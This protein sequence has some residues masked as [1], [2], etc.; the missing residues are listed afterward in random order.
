MVHVK[1][2]DVVLP[3]PPGH[4]EGQSEIF[5]AYD[6]VNQ[7]TLSAAL[8]YDNRVQMHPDLNAVAGYSFGRERWLYDAGFA[9][10]SQMPRHDREVGR[11]AGRD[12]TYRL[13]LSAFGQGGQD[14]DSTRIA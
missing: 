7:V 5:G 3:L 12:L 8:R 4:R 1:R 9:Q 6:R 11:A 10:H 13:G 2:D 14:R